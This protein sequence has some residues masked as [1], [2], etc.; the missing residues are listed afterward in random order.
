M[1]YEESELTKGFINTYL[2]AQVITTNYLN[3]FS[4]KYNAD[5]SLVREALALD[6]R[7]GKFAYLTPGLGLSGGNIER[8]LKAI[9]DNRNNLKINDRLTKLFLQYS[10]Y[11]KKWPVR[12]INNKFINKKIG[13]LGFTYKE[14]TLSTKNAP[15]RILLRYN[16]LIHDYQ[17]EQLEKLNENKNLKFIKLEE[18]LEKCQVIC[19]FHN[20]KFYRKINFKKYKNIKIIL[21]PF[22]IL[23]S[24]LIINKNN[25]QYFCL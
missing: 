1:K 18:V 3:E 14:N 20:H 11:F 4:K 25:I 24:N 23:N 5:W 6:K 2:A 16:C 9:S 17:S 15:S 21:D 19:I 10:D 13:I 12:N 22:K 7:I 8:D